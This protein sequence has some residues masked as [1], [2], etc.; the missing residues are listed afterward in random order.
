MLW[1]GASLGDLNVL[2]HRATSAEPG[3]CICAALSGHGAFACAHGELHGEQGCCKLALWPCSCGPCIEMHLH[4]LV[5]GVLETV[6]WVSSHLAVESCLLFMSIPWLLCVW[7]CAAAQDA[8]K[9]K[10]AHL[11]LWDSSEH[12]CKMPSIASSC[13]RR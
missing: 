6:T 10:S 4:R 9:A 11:L 3:G 13:C 12:S 1:D 5:F 7:G 8:E 2:Y